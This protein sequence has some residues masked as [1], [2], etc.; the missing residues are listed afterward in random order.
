VV[1]C[2]VCLNPTETDAFG[3]MQ[4]HPN[5]VGSECVMSGKL[6]AR[7]DERSTRAAVDTRSGGRC[8]YCRAR[9]ARDMHHR[10]GSGVGGRWHPANIL[11]LCRKC[12]R[13]IT[14][15]P[16]W[17]HSLGL[18]LKEAEDPGERP[19]TREDGTG[20]Q[21]SDDVAPPPLTRR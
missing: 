8:E 12:H 19:V 11:H 6:G 20:F 21:P 14:D 3:V 5:S 16:G 17:A 15:H 13:F 2:P 18:R 1:L 9:P 7:W 4:P 10:R